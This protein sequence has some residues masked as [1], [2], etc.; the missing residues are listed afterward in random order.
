MT[1][2][3]Q[4]KCEAF[5]CIC[6]CLPK[7]HM[8]FPIINQ[9]VPK[10]I[11]LSRECAEW[12]QKNPEDKK[13]LL[14]GRFSVLERAEAKGAITLFLLSPTL[15]L[16]KNFTKLFAFDKELLIKGKTVST[17]TN[18]VIREGREVKLV[19]W[20]AFLWYVLRSPLLLIAT[21]FQDKIIDKSL[22]SC[23]LS[24]KHEASPSGTTHWLASTP[25]LTLLLIL[26]NRDNIYPYRSFPNLE[27]YKDNM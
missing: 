13:P 10:K 1:Q 16:G 27:S 18:R 11:S 2:S 23:S 25:S 20:D 22:V 24:G 14:S 26:N 4:N 15:N 5:I 8:V 17:N 3:Y 9:R 21:S 7:A 12:S 19:L 6:P